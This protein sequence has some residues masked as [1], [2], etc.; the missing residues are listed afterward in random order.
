M[1]EILGRNEPDA[2]ELTDN[3]QESNW[4]KILLPIRIITECVFAIATLK[5]WLV[6]RG[7]DVN[8]NIVLKNMEL[9][10]EILNYLSTFAQKAKG[11]GNIW[12]Q[13][14]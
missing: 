13:A 14:W 2:E 9:S 4:I 10:T 8:E 1:A 5:M 6:L 7:T 3:I 11:G 12:P